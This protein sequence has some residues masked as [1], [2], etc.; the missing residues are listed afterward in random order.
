[1]I[2]MDFRQAEGLNVAPL[3][4]NVLS[5]AKREMEIRIGN[6]DNGT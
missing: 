4:C 5:G 3:S 2:L 6:M 1:L